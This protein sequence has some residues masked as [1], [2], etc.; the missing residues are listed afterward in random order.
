[1]LGVSIHALQLTGVV[2][3]HLLPLPTIDWLGFYPSLEV[4]LP[5]VVLLL[6]IFWLSLKNKEETSHEK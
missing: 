1:M 5:Q 3:N 4:L 6:A 2:S